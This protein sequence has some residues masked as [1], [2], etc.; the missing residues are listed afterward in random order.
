MTSLNR[1]IIILRNIEIDNQRV[2][3]TTLAFPD[4]TLPF[5]NVNL[6]GIL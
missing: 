5:F 6:P 4:K 2:S 1:R 3:R